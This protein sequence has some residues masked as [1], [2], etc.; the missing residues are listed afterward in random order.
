MLASVQDATETTLSLTEV[1]YGKRAF[2]ESWM[3]R[4]LVS[5]Q[6]MLMPLFRV[7]LFVLNPLGNWRYTTLIGS[8][9]RFRLQKK[10]KSFSKQKQLLAETQTF[11]DIK[12]VENQERLIVFHASALRR[13]LLLNLYAYS[14]MLDW[15]LGIAF[16]AFL[17][18]FR[19]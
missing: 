1:V 12:F 18:C 11:K 3:S 5:L 13:W 6:S 16:M 2:F 15:L 17:F 9:T 10:V 14:F 8:N 4:L 19:S 7:W